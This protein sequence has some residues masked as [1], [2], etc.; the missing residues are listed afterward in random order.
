MIKD[1]KIGL[2]TDIH[3]GLNQDSIVWHNIVLE[4]AEWCS[5]KFLEKGIN[6][7]II[8]GDV[9]HNRSEIS[10]ATLDTAKKFFDC[11]KDFQIYILAGNHDSF[12]K[13]HS[14]VNSIS[15]LDGWSNIKIIDKEPKEF[16]MRNKKGVLVP[17][18][19]KFEDIPNSDVCF[20]HFEI[21]SFYMNTYKV[22]EH[23]MSSNDLFKKAK[24]IISGHFHK[25]DHRKYD[26]GEIIYLG[27]PYQ[28]NFGDT[29]DD[30]GVYIYDIDK[31]EFEFIENDISPKYFKLSVNKILTGEDIGD[32]LKNKIAKNHISL[33]VDSHIDSDKLT[34]LSSKIQKHL[35]VNFR[36]D[37]K[38]PDIKINTDRVEKKLEYVNIMDDIESYI[39]NIDIKNKK[40]LT[41]YIKEIYSIN[42]I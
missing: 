41:D 36:L 24:T 27:S 39:N 20:G 32:D 13:D 23:G 19:T 37:Y 28:Q 6:D 34:I 31:N 30:R 35:P 1:S 11:F 22:C 42:K 26:N 4:F 29:L 38:E 18:G 25:K 9:F 15:L 2:F 12:Y 7:I 33:V 21:V 17:W 8:C 10:V 3:I 14:L 40:E 5:K 16:K